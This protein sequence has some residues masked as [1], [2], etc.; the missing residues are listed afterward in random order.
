MSRFAALNEGDFGPNEPGPSTGTPR[1]ATRQPSPTPTLLP[2]YN[3]P[4][5]SWEGV[6]YATLEEAIKAS[7]NARDINDDIID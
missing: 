7:A 1:P 4:T 6:D 3:P 2:A 5:W